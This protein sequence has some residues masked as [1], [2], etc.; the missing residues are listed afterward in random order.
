MKSP[1]KHKALELSCR[2]SKNYSFRMLELE[3]TEDRISR[4]VTHLV[5]P[6]S[7]TRT[8]K[9]RQAAR[10]PHIKVVNQQ[11]LLDSMSKWERQDESRYLVNS[12]AFFRFFH[13]L[14]SE[15]CTCSQISETKGFTTS[16]SNIPFI[17][18]HLHLFLDIF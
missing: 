7:K 16:V 10:Y 3:L 2:Q 12:P 6:T 18:F 1:Y 13:P 9:V 5:T 15:Q 14:Q 17:Y 11:W 8:Q 4:K